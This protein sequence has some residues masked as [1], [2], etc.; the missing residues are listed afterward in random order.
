MRRWM[1]LLLGPLGL[2][3]ADAPVG[4]VIFL[5]PDGTSLASWMA[6]RFLQVG[7][8]GQLNW[9]RLPHLAVYDGRMTDALSAS[10]NG[11]ATVHAW[12]VRAP[13]AAFGFP[14]ASARS[15]SGF[16]GPIMREAQAAGRAVGLVQSGAHYEPGSAVHLVSAPKR[17]DEAHIM[18]DLIA[19]GAA[20]LLGGGERWFLPEGTVGRHGPGQRKDG[21]NLVEEARRAGYTVL[22]N[23]EE[24]QA[25]TSAPGAKFLGLF[26]HDHTFNDRPEEELRAAQLPNYQPQAPTFAEMTAFALRVLAAHPGGFFLVAEEEGTDNFANKNNAAGVLEAH[27]RADAGI[28]VA[29]EF[30][31][32]HPDT[33]VVVA[34]DSNAGSMTVM[35]PRAATLD[36]AKPLPPRDANGAPIDGRDGTGTLPFVARPDENGQALPFWISWGAKDDTSGG[37]IIRAEG[38]NAER[39]RGN[40]DNIDLYRLMYLTLFGRELPRK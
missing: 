19:S 9:D 16:Q 15:L 21:R 35:G 12:G 26:A 34:A 10:S 18:V 31:A 7:P 4:N 2:F 36:P 38:L 25:A 29:R 30:L 32:Q 5:H 3:A 23:R 33:L 6:T 20:V 24:L 39:L 13:H 28:G 27:A 1:F 11:G 22:F 17:A 37:V 14:D 40:V 8:A